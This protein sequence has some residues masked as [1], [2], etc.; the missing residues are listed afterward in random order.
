MSLEL[1]DN[2]IFRLER[3]HH[4]TATPALTDALLNKSIIL[5]KNMDLYDSR[6]RPPPWREGMEKLKD[7]FMFDGKYEAALAVVR[8]VYETLVEGE[9]QFWEEQIEHAKEAASVRSAVRGGVY[10]PTDRWRR[11]A[12]VKLRDLTYL[13][14]VLMNE[15]RRRD[16]LIV[17]SV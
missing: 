1:I 4:I 17:G 9:R 10:N 3:E 12:V 11:Q 15:H 13:V 16:R 14:D 5:Y 7:K 6:V 8:E 2:V